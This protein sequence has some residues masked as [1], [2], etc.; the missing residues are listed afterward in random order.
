MRRRLHRTILACLLAAVPM[1]VHAAAPAVKEAPKLTRAPELLGFVAAP[2]P[3]GELGGAAVVLRI[4]IDVAGLVAS[5]EVA[6]SAGPAFD[7]AAREAVLKFR[8]SPAEVDGKPS[9]IKILYRYEFKPKAP[10]PPPSAGFEGVVRKRGSGE[11]LAG[12][13]V[14]VTAPGAA[15][16]QATTDAQGQFRFDDVAPGEASVGLAGE[17]LTAVQTAETLEAGKQLVVAYEVSLIEPTAA[18]T[19][20]DDLEIQVIAPAL[21]RELVSTAVRAEEASKVP[22]T[23]GDVLRVVESLPGVAR[24]SAGSGQLIVWGAAPQDTRV[25]VDGV[26][27]PRLYHEGGLRS[28]IHPMLVDTVELMP[29]GY[30]SAWGR[31]L[32]GLVSTTTRT[33][34]GERVR[35]RGAADLLDASAVVSGPLG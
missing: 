22:G 10:P 8:F 23:S 31:G 20:Q 3:G 29:G 33:P 2:H 16:Q 28:V 25:Y 1:T 6:E 24:S 19:E 5:A 34:T 18:P 21:R 15:P 11:P 4:Q 13:T 12:V 14:T 7:A 9:P 17:R 35:G 27:I 26:P 30:G 32:G